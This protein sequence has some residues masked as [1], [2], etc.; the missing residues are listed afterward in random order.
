MLSCMVHGEL[1]DKLY[2]KQP[3]GFVDST[4]LNYVCKLVK[5]LYGLKQV[6]RTWNAKFTVYLP[7]IGFQ[8][9]HSDTTLFIKHG[10]EDVIAL[11]LYVD[12]IIFT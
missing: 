3:Q 4:L 2:M 10:G 1:K 11:L 5:S 8:M 12:D 9:S 6:P 7:A